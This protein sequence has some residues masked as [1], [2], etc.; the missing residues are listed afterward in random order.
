MSSW[1]IPVFGVR[2]L[3]PSGAWHLRRFLDK[4]RP[5]VVLIEGLDDAGPLVSDITLRNTKPPIAILAYT[6]SQPVRTLVYPMARYSPEYQALQWAKENKATV[7][8]IDLPSDIFLGLQ[9]IES[10]RNEQFRKKREEAEPESTEKEEENSQSRWRPERGESIYQRIAARCG[11]PDYDTYWERRFEH[12][13]QDDSYRLAAFELG[14]ALRDEEDPPIWRAENLVRESYMR[15]RIE[16]VISKGVK[17]EQIVAVVGAFHASVLNGDYPAMTDEELSRLRRRSSKL[18]LMP[19]SY[20]KLSTQSGYGAGNHAPAYFELL[21]DSLQR[22]ELQELPGEYLSQV[23]RHLRE[24]GTHR[25]TAEVIE[26]VRLA[27]TLAALQ[28]GSATT[29]RDLRDAAVTLIGHGEA[30]VVREALADID[31]GSAIG[32]LPEG[33]SQTSIQEDFA[34][35]LSRLKLEKYRTSTVQDLK[36]DLRENRRVHS[37]EAAFLDLN[38][39]SFFHRLLMLGIQFATPVLLRQQST[40]WAE[41]WQLK[42]TPESEIALV[43]AVLLGETVELATGFQFKTLLENCKNIG[44]ASDLVTKACQCGLMASMELARQRLQELA[45]TSTDMKVIAHAT[46]QLSQ[47]IRYGDVRRFDPA[48]LLPLM[49]Q[50]FVSGSLALHS[51]A[52]C[53]DDAAKEIVVAI[54]ELN[55][56]SLEHHDLVDEALWLE[57]LRRLS[58][59]DDRNPLLSGFACATLLER[60][61]IENAELVREVS[62]RLSPGVPADLGAGWFEGLAKRNR[63]SLLARQSLWEA[64]DSYIASL[65]PDQFK[66]A[67]VFLR[68]A[69]GAF[70]PREKRQICENLA[71]FWGVDEEK[72]FDAV[73]KPLSEEEEKTL[74]D[75][76]ELDFG[77]F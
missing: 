25:S 60:N 31:I 44:E 6:D 72:T 32:E 39:S 49:E 30:L 68:R 28:E 7:E 23:A 19:Y 59:A 43:E 27:R 69:F 54:E 47:V 29:L 10:E 52:N 17:A 12:N 38:R 46:F 62:R 24:R 55:R 66:R 36:L 70:S 61:L 16:E 2:H 8:F 14:K 35:E 63:H 1:R 15:R 57:Q 45:A 53:N 9:D 40:T 22:R 74:K 67:L 13:L 34:R 18:T 73:A 50:L 58:D 77:D 56:V 11:E 42:W 71:H 26:G 20:Y 21:W 65:D 48:P 51:A 33:V 5:K 37:E 3:S 4:V 76:N 64:L 41:H 75:L